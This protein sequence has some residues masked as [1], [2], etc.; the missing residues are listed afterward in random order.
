VDSLYTNAALAPVYEPTFSSQSV[1]DLN[2]RKSVLSKRINFLK[3]QKFPQTAIEAIYRSFTSAIHDRGVE[4]AR[5]IIIHG[6]NYQGEDKKIKNLIAECDPY[7][8]KWLTK[9]K[10]YRKIYVLPTST[11]IGGT[12]QYLMKVNIK[13]PSDAKFP[14]FDINVKLPMEIARHAGAQQWYKSMTFNGKILKNEGRFTITAPSADTNYEM[15]I[16]P[17]QVNKSGNNV[18]E[19]KF[20]YDSFKV[21]EVSIMGQRPI[22]KKD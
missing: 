11:K 12:N 1:A 16:T 22:M 6:K 18:L 10:Q 4:K 2:K 7:A 13:I 20:D 3:H 15:Q 5:A 17:L 19:I 9:A 21:F 8:A 14:V